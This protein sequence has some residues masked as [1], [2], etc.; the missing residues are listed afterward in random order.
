MAPE[1]MV[2]RI[3]HTAFTS[4]KKAREYGVIINGKPRLT[5]TEC[6]IHGVKFNYQ[7]DGS[8]APRVSRCPMGGELRHRD[9]ASL[10]NLKKKLVMGAPCHCA[11][12]KPMTHPP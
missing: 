3:Y 10:H 5:S 4:M 2:M 9:A 6:P 12:Q 8:N 1:R 7:P 11:R